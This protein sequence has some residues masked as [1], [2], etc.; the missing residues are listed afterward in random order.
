MFRAL[1]SSAPYGIFR[2]DTE[3]R[4]AYVNERWCEL[5]GLTAEQA[6]GDG[7]TVAVHPEDLDGVRAGVDR[8]AAGRDV[9]GPIEYR[10]VHADGSVRWMHGSTS[11]VHDAQQHVIGCL[12]T[13]LDVTAAKQT[14][15][16]LR[17]SERFRV[18]F[19]NAPIGV[20]LLTPDGRWFH[21]N[22]ALCDLLGYTVAELQE[23]TFADVT[24]PD[25]LAANLERSR[26]QLEGDEWEMRIEKRYVRSDGTIVWVAL[27]NEVVRDDS[28]EPLYF[29]AQIEDIT[30]RRE[31]ERALQEAEER[32]RRAFEDGPIGMALV[33]LDGRWLRVNR[34]LCEMT[35][36]SEADLLERTFQDITHPDDI[37]E[38]VDR[39]QRLLSSE[40]RA[41]QTEKR[42]L[43]PDGEIVWAALSVSVVRDEED[44]PLYFV[45]QIEDIRERKRAEHELQRLAAFDPLT[46]LGNR[47]KLTADL[48]RMLVPGH[49][50]SHLFVVFDLNG[51]KHY[52]DTFGHPAG[53]ALLAR[54]GAKLAV[55]VESHGEAYRLG[56]DEFCVLASASPHD[57]E[58]FLD[59]AVASLE[60]SGDGF[61]IS[62]SFGAIF[63]P[64]EAADATSALSLAD[65]RLY[66]QKNELR[67]LRGQP[68][69]VLLRA[70]DERQ[71]GL[72]EHIDELA[73]LAVAVGAGLGLDQEAL[74][75]L[76]L[77]AELHDVGKLAMPDAVLQKEGPLTEAEWALIRQH[78]LIGQRI[79]GAAPA[80]RTIGTIVRSTHERWDGTG[81]VDGLAGDEIPLA[82][83]IV[84]VCDAYVAMT[85]DRPYRPAKSA[86][87]AIAELQRCAGT[88]F[89]PDVVRIVCRELE[90]QRTQAP[91]A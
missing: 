23:L 9:D 34:A 8:A 72:R 13:C 30:Q 46:G 82:A 48:E 35:G 63:L 19:D 54:L 5:S 22:Q 57:A 77:A 81:Y 33:G 51:F 38:G 66:A 67:G 56:G 88:Q 58:A 91:A 78:T 12:G 49:E 47:R 4:C 79:L 3:G 59:A 1:T 86:E 52:N 39:V 29:V 25:D 18:A 32:F 76:R 15:E 74:T 43:R 69:D 26:K 21:V 6:L 31:T 17:S 62:S 40:I 89:D 71:P 10:F 28:G 61:R 11:A 84:A 36:Y 50:E 85:S 64:E 60:E 42:Y 27:S 73:E 37:D 53:D 55:A 41:Y 68:H 87:E 16:A 20:A 80:L 44:T 83:R 70:I 24:H 65:E 90:L 14:E 45:S 2:L 75:E 7:W